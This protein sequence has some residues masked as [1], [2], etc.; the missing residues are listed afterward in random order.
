[1][2]ITATQIVGELA[3]LGIFPEALCDE[4]YF[5]PSLEWLQEYIH[6]FWQ[7]NPYKYKK[8]KFDCDNFAKRAWAQADESLQENRDIQDCDHTFC[9]VKLNLLKTL[10][11]VSGPGYHATNMVRC[12]NNIWYFAEPQSGEIH[13]VKTAI[14]DGLC[15]APFTVW[16]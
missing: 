12:S 2:K 5:C 16:M 9:M 7:N 10:N 15:D 11:G 13:E 1:M 14:A 6:W 8:E 3:E 4:F